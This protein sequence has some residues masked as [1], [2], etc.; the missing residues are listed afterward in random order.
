MLTALTL[1]LPVHLILPLLFG[2]HSNGMVSP[3]WSKHHALRLSV[4]KSST[5]VPSSV[6]SV[7]V[8]VSC[9]PSRKLMG[10]SVLFDATSCTLVTLVLKLRPSPVSV[11][12]RRPGPNVRTAAMVVFLSITWG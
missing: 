5:M 2:T 6:Q 4:S 1:T 9:E 7:L 11:M 12:V 8:L 10:S 3:E